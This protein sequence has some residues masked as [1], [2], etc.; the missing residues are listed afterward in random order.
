MKTNQIRVGERY[1]MKVSDRLVSVRVL[2]IRRT[3]REV[4]KSV[5]RSA[6]REKTTFIVVN[7]S[8]GRELTVKSPQR[9]R[10]TAPYIYSPGGSNLA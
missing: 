2:D 3:I 4:R 6:Y 5:G 9:F 8:T 7:E 1:M 10:S